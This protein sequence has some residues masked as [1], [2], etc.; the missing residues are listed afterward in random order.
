MSNLQNTSGKT[1][2]TISY[3][4]PAEEQQIL[5]QQSGGMPVASPTR[6]QRHEDP[7]SS[8][9]E[10][11]PARV[12]AILESPRGFNPWDLG[13]LDNV[14]QVLGYNILDWFLPMRRSP[15]ASH[16]D[17]GSMFKLGSQVQRLKEDAGLVPGIEPV[18]PSPEPAHRKKR[19]RHRSGEVSDDDR[20]RH[21]PRRHSRHA[22]EER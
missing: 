1:L 15:C 17:G 12:F 7:S 2:R 11:M 16:T 5:L 10:T 19:R 20:K 4:R 6:F 14:R 3:P 18:A 8:R 21:R 9:S 13:A 22:R